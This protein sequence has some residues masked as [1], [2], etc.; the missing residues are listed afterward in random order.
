[1]LRSSD[2]Q[3]PAEMLPIYLNEVEEVGRVGDGDYIVVTH[4]PPTLTDVTRLGPYG[5]EPVGDVTQSVFANDDGRWWFNRAGVNL[6]AGGT[7]VFFIEGP[8]LRIRELESDWWFETWMPVAGP[9]PRAIA[10]GVDEHQPSLWFW[11]V[12]PGGIK[13]LN[14]FDWWQTAEH[15]ESLHDR[16]ARVTLHALRHAGAPAPNADLGDRSREALGAR[17]DELESIGILAETPGRHP[18]RALD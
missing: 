3:F 17:T 18:P 14:G 11:E 7:S 16:L 9:K 6:E 12:T 4:R 13:P 15:V 5:E 10:V 8:E 2:D 1:M